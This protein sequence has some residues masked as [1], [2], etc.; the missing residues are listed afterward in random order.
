[1]F[2]QTPVDGPNGVGQLVAPLRFPHDSSGTLTDILSGRLASNVAPMKDI[3]L[4]VVD[5]TVASAPSSDKVCQGR[6][7]GAPIKCC[8][9]WAT[10]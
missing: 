2:F 5:V 7:C 8:S 10:R 4:G 9:A 6:D 1:M 3:D